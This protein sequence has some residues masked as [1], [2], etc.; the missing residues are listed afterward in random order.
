MKARCVCGCGGPAHQRHHVVYAQEVRRR[1]GS[2]RDGR[3]LISVGCDCHAAHHQR[4]RPFT[5][6]VLPDS[7][8][9]FAAEL[10]GPDA[11]YEYL[12]RRY[13]GADQRLVALLAAPQA[14]PVDAGVNGGLDD[15][16]GLQGA[17]R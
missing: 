16:D 9:E 13:A 8:F 12:R 2:L 6:W 15:H 10:L 17:G 5:L 1:G 3:N 11:A 4:R 14:V 7:A